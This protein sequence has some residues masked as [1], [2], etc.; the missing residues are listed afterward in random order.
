MELVL[1]GLSKNPYM[2]ASK[3]REHIK[4][5]ADYFREAIEGRYE[6]LLMDESG[7]KKTNQIICDDKD[8]ATITLRDC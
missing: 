4:W 6:A 1:T 7:P 5:F 2:T 8:S 3:K